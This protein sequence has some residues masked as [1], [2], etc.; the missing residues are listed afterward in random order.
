[1]V[2]V[3]IKDDRLKSYVEKV[4]EKIGGITKIQLL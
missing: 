3:V 4:Y 2:E 1:M